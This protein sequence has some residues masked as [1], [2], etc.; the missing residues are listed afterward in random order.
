MQDSTNCRY[1]KTIRLGVSAILLRFDLHQLD[2][3]MV[4][5]IDLIDVFNAFIEMDSSMLDMFNNSYVVAETL[6]RENIINES[7]YIDGIDY[8]TTVDTIKLMLDIL[9]SSL[10]TFLI[11]KN[12]G[13][14]WFLEDMSADTLFI[15]EF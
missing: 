9:K 2:L 15:K 1:P 3:S 4:D 6:V 12:P 8:L 7:I 13:T 10:R 14:N 5:G 11:Y